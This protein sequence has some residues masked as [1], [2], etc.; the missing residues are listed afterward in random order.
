MSNFEAIWPNYF[1]LLLLVAGIRVL[2]EFLIIYLI[3]IIV[4]QR[5]KSWGAVGSFNF[6]R[7]FLLGEARFGS[8]NAVLIL[9][10]I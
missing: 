8:L 7:E 9:G 2:S 3:F 4:F 10:F 5:F 1:Y 6:E